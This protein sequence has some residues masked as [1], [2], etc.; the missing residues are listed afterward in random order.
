MNIKKKFKIL[1]YE[2]K[3]VVRLMTERINADYTY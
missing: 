1:L 2:T 3:Y